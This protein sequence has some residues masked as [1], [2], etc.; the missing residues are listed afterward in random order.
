[1]FKM[2]STASL[3][4]FIFFASA[5]FFTQP[6]L[7]STTLTSLPLKIA[8]ICQTSDGQALAII[9]NTDSGK[10]DVFESGDSIFGLAKVISVSTRQVLIRRLGQRELESLTVLAFGSSADINDVDEKTASLADATLREDSAEIADLSQDKSK[11]TQAAA[12]QRS[13]AR[14]GKF[15][16]GTSKLDNK[17]LVIVN[18]S[19]LFELSLTNPLTLLAT[20]K[21]KLLPRDGKLAVQIGEV[22]P[23]SIGDSLGFKANDVL[24]SINGLAPTSISDAMQN[25]PAALRQPIVEINYER[26]GKPQVINITSQIPADNATQAVATASVDEAL[27]KNVLDSAKPPAE[28]GTMIKGLLPASAENS[29]SAEPAVALP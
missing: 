26:D 5:A 29:N 9:E 28:L 7:A 10:Q 18:K 11:L 2:K 21:P 23:N 14:S 22:P 25:L 12:A 8:A 15:V 17:P 3:A 13:V 1:M 27:L 4:A 20:F 24:T 6:C 16:I 19:A